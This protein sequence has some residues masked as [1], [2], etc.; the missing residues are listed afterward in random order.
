[1]ESRY[2]TLGSGPNKVLVLHDFFANTAS[3]DGLHAFLD[4]E[5]STYVF[6]DLRGYGRS[7]DI[8]GEY[9]L[10]E[11]TQD[12]LALVDHLGWDTF[13]AVGHSMTGLTVQ[14]LNYTAPERLESVTAITPVP[15]IGSAIPEDF[16]EVIRTGIKGNDEIMSEI[17]RNASGMRYNDAFIQ[18]KL[19][20]FRASATV[21][22][23]L[24]YL[25]M[26]TQ[27]DIS[28]EV[29]GLQTPYHVIIGKCDSE[30]HNREVMESTF[31]KYFPN[32]KIS[33]IADASHYPMQETPILLASHIES[34]ILKQSLS[35][36]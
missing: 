19:K 28:N 3:Y 16:L 9:T 10:N 22:A 25:N 7:K 12:C 23:R 14:H 6:F 15:A 4:Q 32:C 1:M 5:Q 31:A 29:Q 30:W 27:N 11:V 21:D 26:F 34:F 35:A 24:G 18:F 33:E 36:V 20:Q 17:I 8:E 2:Q 13:H